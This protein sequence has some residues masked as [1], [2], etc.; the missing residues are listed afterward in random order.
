MNR[1]YEK[2]FG[3][4]NKSLKMFLRNLA[5]FDRAFCDA[6]ADRIDFTLKLEVKGN[7]GT[8]IHVRV[9]PDIWER[10]EA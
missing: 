7:K 10:P 9:S 2:V 5:K 1:D 3:G 8:L 6:M 4:N